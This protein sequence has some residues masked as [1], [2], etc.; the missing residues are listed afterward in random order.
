M[1]PEPRTVGTVPGPRTLILALVVALVAGGIGAPAAAPRE[2]TLAQLRAATA[3]TSPSRARQERTAQPRRA[4]LT[5]TSLLVAPPVTAFTASAP[6]RG[7][8]GA[9]EYAVPAAAPALD[10]LAS[11]SRAPPR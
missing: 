9:C 8:L 5:P 11:R 1:P 3:G 4:R 7:L 2:Q 6:D 10:P